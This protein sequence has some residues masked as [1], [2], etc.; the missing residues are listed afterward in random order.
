MNL[1]FFSSRWSRLFF[2]QPCCWRIQVA[3]MLPAATMIAN[4]VAVTVT[5]ATWPDKLFRLNQK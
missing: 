5:E 3:S 1:P 4:T 2:S